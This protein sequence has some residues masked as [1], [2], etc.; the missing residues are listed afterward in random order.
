MF[1]YRNDDII[2]LEV[3][4]LPADKTFFICR[5]KKKPTSSPLSGN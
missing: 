3:V 1:V 2:V 4:P 5:F